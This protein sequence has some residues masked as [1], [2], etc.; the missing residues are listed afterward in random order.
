MIQKIF[1]FIPSE[2]KENQNIS[3]P[4][5]KRK[6]DYDSTTMLGIAPPDA[7][8]ITTSSISGE[9]KVDKLTKMIGSLTEL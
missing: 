1:C 4:W 5:I 6:K 8:E 7:D 3:D 9:S 2:L